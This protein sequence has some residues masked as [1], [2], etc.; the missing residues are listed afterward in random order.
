VRAHESVQDIQH[1]N[2]P[3]IF[4]WVDDDDAESAKRA[5][6]HVMQDYMRRKRMLARSKPG[7][8]STR[9]LGWRSVDS[10]VAGGSESRQKVPIARS[11]SALHRSKR[12]KTRSKAKCRKKSIT[13]LRNST[14]KTEPAKG[15]F[16]FLDCNCGYRSPASS[17]WPPS[18]RSISSPCSPFALSLNNALAV[19]SPERDYPSPSSLLG[20]GVVD[21]FDCFPVTLRESDRGLISHCEL[22]SHYGS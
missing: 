16:Q 9:P 11:P 22:G 21:P 14:S 12:S 13:Q 1:A 19:G 4:T 17:S 5:R 18:P 2:I 15:D 20:A 7:N 3:Q 10:S 6:R 8:H